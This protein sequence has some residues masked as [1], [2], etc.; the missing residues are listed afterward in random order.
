[1]IRYFFIL[2]LLLICSCSHSNDDPLVAQMHM[3]NM[4]TRVYVNSSTKTVV[5]EI[6]NLLQDEG[7]IVKNVNMELGLVSAERNMDIEKFSSK[8]WAYIFS[9]KNASW[10]KYSIVEMTTNISEHH[11]QSKVRVNFLLKIYDNHGRQQEVHPIN[12]EVHYQKFFSK[13]Q[14]GLLSHQTVPAK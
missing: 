6:I 1:M 10:K 12:D 2:I 9:G 11:N 13:L 5:K 4:Q 3:R 8:F 7:Y 14:R